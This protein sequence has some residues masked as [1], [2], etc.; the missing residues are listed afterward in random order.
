[1]SAKGRVQI[2]A[3][4]VE[5]WNGLGVR[6]VVVHGFD[7]YPTTIGRDLD[8]LVREEDSPILLSAAHQIFEREG[9]IA[10]EPPD[11]W[12]KRIVAF[13]GQEALEIHTITRLSWREIDL[14]S[15]PNPARL[16]KGIFPVDPWAS[17]AKQILMPGFHGDLMKVSSNLAALSLVGE[18]RQMIHQSLEAL[19]LP[20]DERLAE[21]LL[22]SSA[23]DLEALLPSLRGSMVKRSWSRAP[24]S[25]LRSLSRKVGQRADGLIRPTGVTIQLV[26]SEATE[27]KEVREWVTST[28]RSIFTD[29]VFRMP[30]SG[31][32]Q[33]RIGLLTD[34]LWRLWLRLIGDRMALSGQRVVFHIM[35]A[36]KNDRVSHDVIARFSQWLDRTG[37]QPLTTL[38][39]RPSRKANGDAGLME[40]S[41]ENPGDGGNAIVRVA[42]ESFVRR[43][44]PANRDTPP[45]ISDLDGPLP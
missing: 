28:E 13:S 15:H 34:A 43:H 24:L 32:R 4:L 29:F 30:F 1:M 8:I 26:T 23:G 40:V 41:G 14:V 9:W 27:P 35:K 36:T 39:I 37:S 18:D 22:E 42:I 12:G 3:E 7:G 45:I 17:Y 19:L 33:S 11:M 38:V 20:A 16:W 6:Y 21:A 5:A 31:F 10:I 2:A 25:A 44:S